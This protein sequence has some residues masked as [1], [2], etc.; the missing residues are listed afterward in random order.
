MTEHCRES[1]KSIVLDR[2]ILSSASWL[3]VLYQIKIK[4]LQLNVFHFFGTSFTDDDYALEVM[5]G[6]IMDHFG[7][8]GDIFRVLDLHSFIW[9]GPS[10][11]V[12]CQEI[13]RKCFRGLQLLELC[14]VQIS[15]RILLE[16]ID[17]QQDTIKFIILDRIILQ[18]ASWLHVL[19][20]IKIKNLQLDTSNFF[21]TIFTGDEG[22]KWPDE[23]WTLHGR[24][25]RD[26]RY[27]QCALG[28]IQRQV[29]ANSLAMRPKPWPDAVY[30]CLSY[31]AL[32]SF[33]PPWMYQRL[34]SQSG[35]FA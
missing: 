22:G 35:W 29:N 10:S 6:Q 1:I 17:H 9:R 20:Q 15:A 27:I 14:D 8:I 28:Y 23:E 11:Y 33:I 3:H 21:G 32:Q 2:I 34:V 7:G 18:S 24:F 19:Y 30:R 25:F 26:R 5:G 31:E 16:M 13:R 12:L 4:S